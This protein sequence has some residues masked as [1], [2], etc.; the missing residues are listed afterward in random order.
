[1]LYTSPADI[2]TILGIDPIE[3][4]HPDKDTWIIKLNP[5]KLKRILE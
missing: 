3:I 5:M 2:L 1:L 4:A